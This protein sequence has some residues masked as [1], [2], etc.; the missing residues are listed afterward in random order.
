MP[1]ARPLTLPPY[2]LP[3]VSQGS[4]IHLLS[5]LFFSSVLSS[6]LPS[7]PL[8]LL[9]S[10]NLFLSSSP[11]Q[12]P[13]LVLW[14][15]FFS[16]FSL[17]FLLF[18]LFLTLSLSLSSHTP[19]FSFLPP[20]RGQINWV[21]MAL[22]LRLRLVQCALTLPAA[23]PPA[24]KPGVPRNAAVPSQAKRAGGGGWGGVNTHPRPRRAT[25]CRA[26]RLFVFGRAKEAGHCLINSK[27][28]KKK[29]SPFVCC[30]TFPRLSLAE[31]L[32]AVLLGVNKQIIYSAGCPSLRGTNQMG[33]CSSHRCLLC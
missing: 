27:A 20:P 21:A 31:K 2:T 32:P 16:K 25:P 10:S 18:P 30:E 23:G 19:S 24:E 5:S 33:L 1:R 17:C 7:C 22:R 26:R 8:R 29:C 9:F 4:S 28:K 12:T 6:C 11:S 15:S 14:V 13:S 3:T